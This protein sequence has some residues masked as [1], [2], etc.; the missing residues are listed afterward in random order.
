MV[1]DVREALK[2]GEWD[3]AILHPPCTYLTRSGERWLRDPADFDAA[4][5][6]FLSCWN[7]PVKRVAVE[8]P[9][10]G[11]R[12]RALIPPPQ[13]YVQPHMFGDARYKETGL[14]LRKVPPLFVTD[15]VSE[16]ARRLPKKISHEVHYMSPSPDRARRRSET[17]P[18][19]AN[20]MA[21]QWG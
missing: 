20:A 6:L 14:W 16:I 17:Y 4:V 18:G 19:F 3:L 7:A 13:Q 5:E 11:A 21:A 15:D 12:A 9:R 8:N 2:W 10:M 1:D